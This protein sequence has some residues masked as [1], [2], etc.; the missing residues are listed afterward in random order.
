MDVSDSAPFLLGK[1]LLESGSL[2]EEQLEDAL[3]EQ[4]ITHKRLGSILVSKGIITAPELTAGLVAQIGGETEPVQTAAA[5]VPDEHRPAEGDTRSSGGSRRFRRGK[6]RAQAEAELQELRST[7]EVQIGDLTR[8]LEQA[9]LELAARD[10]RLTDLES[11]LHA[12]ER[13]RGRLLDALRAEVQLQESA[14]QA[15]R[16]LESA[17]G[18]GKPAGEPAPSATEA[19]G[20]LA[21]APRPGGGHSLLELDGRPPAVGS[22][23]QLGDRRLVVA[24]HGP[25]PLAFDPRVCVRLKA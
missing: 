24:S 8:R 13:E 18:N 4:R 3:L 9:T 11:R 17:V 16:R 10:T 20:Y 7:T 25:A 15:V 2:T 1:L 12:S 22:E 21:L 5:V 23:I 14:L 6:A 19:E